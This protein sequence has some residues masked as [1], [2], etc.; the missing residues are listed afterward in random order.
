[1][2]PQPETGGIPSKR[3]VT[4]GELSTKGDPICLVNEVKIQI[5]QLDHYWIKTLLNPSLSLAKNLAHH[6]F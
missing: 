4:V 6:F 5:A 2:D 1:M 3:L